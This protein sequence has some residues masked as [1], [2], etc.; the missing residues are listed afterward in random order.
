MVINEVCSRNAITLEDN[1][2]NFSD[3]IEF[4]NMGV[5]PI[6]LKNWTISDDSAKLDKWIFPDVI[7]YADS[8]LVVFAS[9]R[10]E[11]TIV[12]HWETIIHADSL[13]RY[14]TPFFEPDPAWKDLV[15][16]DSEWLVGPGGFGRGDDDD[17]TVLPDTVPTVYIRKTFEIID[18]SIISSVLLQVDYDDAFVAYI[19]GIEVARSNIGWPGLIQEWDD[20]SR[21]IHHAVMFQGLPPEEFFID[22]DLF[23]A[24]VNEGEN[25][26]A[27]QALNGWNNNGNSSIIPFLSVGVSDNSYTY[28]ELP[29]WFGD[30]PVFL[31]TNFKLSGTGESIY[32]SNPEQIIIDSISFPYTQSDHS[33]GRITDGSAVWKY[34]STPTPN[35]SNDLSPH[36]LGYTKEPEFSLESGYYTG[37]VGVNILNIEPGESVKYSLDGSWITDTSDIYSG[38]IVID[39]TSILRAQIFKDDFLPGSVASNTYFIDFDTELSVISI[40]MNPYDLWDWEE[41]IYVMGPN[42]STS[43]P[44]L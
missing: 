36:Y 27:I 12:N 43:Y 37:S 32:I 42:A 26:L 13:W 17:N 24:I 31:H 44:Y 19:N 34:F 18:T 5:D 8:H 39:S 3:W 30:K 11:K 6:I 1:Y 25:I 22:I 41:G 20:F 9:D 28:L 16:D 15:F 23:K 38:V 40:S 10:D 29:E 4:Y 7:L 21:D 35:Q 33:Y 2:A 14:F